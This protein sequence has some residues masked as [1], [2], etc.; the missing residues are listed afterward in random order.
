MRSGVMVMTAPFPR[1]INEYSGVTSVLAS[2]TEMVP[3]GQ[4]KSRG[5]W[6]TII[7]VNRSGGKIRFTIGG[8][9]AA[10]FAVFASSALGA[11]YSVMR[12]GVMVMTRFRA[13]D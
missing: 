5:E 4:V 9:F 3:G 12:S 11:L 7:R 2:D 8:R 6:L 10:A 13:D 1:D